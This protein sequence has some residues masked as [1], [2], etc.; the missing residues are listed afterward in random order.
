M[1]IKAGRLRERL[2]IQAPSAVRKAL[3][4]TV[5]TWQTEAVVWGEV[6]SLSAQEIV[7]AMQNQLQ[8]THRVTIRYYAGL[9]SEMRLVWRGKTL[10]ILSVLE[11]ENRAIHDLICREVVQ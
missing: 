10:E 7:Q 11:R 3:G 4:E 2:T 1:P 5:L 6:E 8:V 9:T